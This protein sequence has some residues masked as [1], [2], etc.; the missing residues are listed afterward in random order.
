MLLPACLV[1]TVAVGYEWGGQAGSCSFQLVGVRRRDAV[2][3][4]CLV[5]TQSRALAGSTPPVCM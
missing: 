3:W 5:Y 1:A 2:V 4:R